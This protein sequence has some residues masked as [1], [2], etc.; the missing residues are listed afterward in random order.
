MPFQCQIFKLRRRGEAATKAKKSKP[1]EVHGSY[2]KESF[3]MESNE[4]AIYLMRV[5]M[6]SE[7]V[8]QFS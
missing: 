3:L 4:V 2:V 5:V 8:F 1:E 6:Y 7:N